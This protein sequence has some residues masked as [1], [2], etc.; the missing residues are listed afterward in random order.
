MNFPESRTNP[1]CFPGRGVNS[2]FIKDLKA[3]TGPDFLRI[4]LESEARLFA[5]V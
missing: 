3:M 4:G 1:R 2:N 5:P